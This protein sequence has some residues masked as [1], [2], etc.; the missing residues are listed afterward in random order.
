MPKLKYS[1]LVFASSSQ[2]KLSE[3]RTILSLPGLKLATVETVDLQ[4]LNIE[5]LVRRKVEEVKKI[6][7]D[8]P[9]FVEHTGL[10]IDAWKGLPGGLTRQFI[11]TVSVSG[12]CKMLRAYEGTERI[13]RAK[14]IIGYH[15]DGSVQTF[16]GTAIGSIAL[17]PR[18]R[19]DFGWDWDSIFIPEGYTRTYAEMG[20]EEKNRISMRGKAALKFKDEYLS[21]HFES[22]RGGQA[23]LQ[24]DA[25]E[26]AKKTS[27]AKLRENLITHFNESELH[28]LCFD[29]KVDYET[30]P[31]KGKGDKARELIYYLERHGDIPTLLEICNQLRPK[32][33]W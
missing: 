27:R 32:V 1:S 11:K 5:T 22:E 33:S 24:S 7:P 29:L 16:E 30:L 2:L 21:L 31:G 6:I 15:Y 9:F 23:T 20:L 18:A 25:I 17:E 14:T 10:I 4:D 8:T 13:A 12:I 26:A 19:P 3:Y 28:D